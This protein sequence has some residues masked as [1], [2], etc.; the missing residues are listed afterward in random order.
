VLTTEIQAKVPAMEMQHAERDDQLLSQLATETGGVYWKGIEAAMATSEDR[1][2]VVASIE[3]QDQV[4]YLP[5]APDQVFQLRW[6]GWLMALIAGCLSLEW[7]SRRL[8]RLA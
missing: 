1:K 3:P 8:H 5:G 6:L 7:L 4:A 2:N